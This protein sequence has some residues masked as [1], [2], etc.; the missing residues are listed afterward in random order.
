MH[1]ELA[2]EQGKTLIDE[3]LCHISVANL[4][5]L[6]TNATSNNGETS[7]VDF[8]SKYIFA[9][10]N[11]KIENMNKALKLCETAIKTITIIK[12]YEHYM[13]TSGRLSWESYKEK[14]T[15][16]PTFPC[17]MEFIPWGRGISYMGAWNQFH[18]PDGIQSAPQKMCPT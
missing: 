13:S 1:I 17:V 15:Q 16:A 3:T 8:L 18:N 7:R 2:L 11:E 14:V 4:Q 6:S 10:D 12:F 5:K 9:Q